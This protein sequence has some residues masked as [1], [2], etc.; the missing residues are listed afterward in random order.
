MST[1]IKILRT[2][3]L[4]THRTDKVFIGPADVRLTEGEE[5]DLE[6]PAEKASDSPPISTQKY[7]VKLKDGRG[8][9]YLFEGVDFEFI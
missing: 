7:S 3:I 9:V 5:A 1:K 2:A 4:Y 6:K 8:P